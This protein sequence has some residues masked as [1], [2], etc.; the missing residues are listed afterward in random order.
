MAK[1]KHCGKVVE[2]EPSKN[3][4]CSR[5]CLVEMT[6]NNDPQS[7]RERFKHLVYLGTK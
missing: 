2:N 7:E 1:C 4:V 6:T 3:Y 5:D